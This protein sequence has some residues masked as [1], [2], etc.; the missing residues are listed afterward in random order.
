[1][2]RLVAAAAVAC[3]AAGAVAADW[4]PYVLQW[5]QATGDIL[6]AETDTY[7]LYHYRRDADGAVSVES[8]PMSIGQMG[9]GKRREGDMKTPLGIYFVVD[10]IDTTPL[11]PKYG[12]AA[13]PLDYPNARDRQR[14]RTGDG[15]WLHGVMPGTATPIARDTDGCVAL[16]NEVLETL[17]P[18]MRPHVTPL[19]V[20]REIRPRDDIA[21][22]RDE[23]A[24]RVASWAASLGSG[25]MSDYLSH[26]DASAFSYQGLGLEAWSVLQFDELAKDDVAGVSVSDLFIA[27]NP[28]EGDLYV[29]RFVLRV[30]LKDGTTRQQWKRLYWQRDASGAPRIVTEDET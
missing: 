3:W 10:R 5:P 9:A 29:T 8:H 18:R 15:I 17:V 12:S 20:T 30:A 19:I 13:F 14:G 7:T 1:M 27:A 16:A 4:P 22:A 11:H 26:Y 25:V 6:I 24:A 21:A 23:L 28:E 2:L